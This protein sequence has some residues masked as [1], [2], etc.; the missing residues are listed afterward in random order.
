MTKMIRGLE[1]DE[2]DQRMT[3]TKLMSLEMRRLR[4]D[5]I[6]VFKSMHNLEGLR[7]ED[8]FQIRNSGL[9]GHAYT[10]FKQHSRLNCCKYFFSQRAVEE[11]N[12]LPTAA[13]NA[14]MINGFKTQV[15]PLIW[16]HAGLFISQH[17]LPAPVLQISRDAHI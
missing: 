16:Q 3:K 8:F 14:E 10:I 12:K 2:Y 5:L 11:W 7:P 13:V 6:E 1:E 17:K 15:D 9:Q 4:S